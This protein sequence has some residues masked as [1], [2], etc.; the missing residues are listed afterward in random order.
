MDSEKVNDWL[1]IVGM[2]GIIASLVFVGVQVRQTQSIGEGDSATQFFDATISG[3]QFLV[4]NID[5]W[6]KGCAGEEMSVTEEAQFAHMF[7]TYGL[8]SYFAWLGTKNNIL[9]LNPQDI[10]YAFAANIHR[11]PGFK[12]ISL[13]WND[14]AKEGLEF[15]L[16]SSEEFRAAIGARVAELQEIEPGPNYGIEWCGT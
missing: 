7:R 3:K 15:S 13:S 10:V 16:R 9:D 11:Y 5:V 8:A 2:F 1:Q 4:E 6:I 14:W 12:R